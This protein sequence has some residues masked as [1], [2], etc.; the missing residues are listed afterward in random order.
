[1]DKKRGKLLKERE[2]AK[3]EK[4]RCKEDG[5]RRSLRV[6]KDARLLRGT[7]GSH[8]LQ[9][10]CELIDWQGLK[11]LGLPYHLSQKRP[12]QGQSPLAQATI[13]NEES[14]TRNGQP[15]T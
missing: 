2:E 12:G 1:V 15:G 14:P 8:S 11:H 7:S 4:I 9:K 5:V 13:Q 10:G 6:C 3:G